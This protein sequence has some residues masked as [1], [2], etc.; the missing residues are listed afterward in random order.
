MGVRI[1]SDTRPVQV[2]GSSNEGQSRSRLARNELIP[3]SRYLLKRWIG[4]GGMGVI[5]EAEHVDVKRPVAVKILRPEYVTNLQVLEAFRF[6]ARATSD[7]DSPYLVKIHDFFELPDGRSALVMELLEGSD[8]SRRLDSVLPSSRVLGIARQV[9]KALQ[10]VH[11]SG[12]VHRDLK[13]ENI[14]LCQNEGR[15]DTIRVL[16]FGIARL[17]AQATSAQSGGTPMY[18]APEV[19]LG[20]AQ[21]PQAD[22]YALGCVLYELLTGITAFGRDTIDAT[23]QAHLESPP[24]PPSAH[25]TD[26]HPAL[27]AVVLRSLSRHAEDRYADMASFEAALCEAQIAAGLSTAWDDLP[28]PPEIPADQRDRLLAGM[29]DPTLRRRSNRWSAWAV[30]FAAVALTG[31]GVLVFT[32]P[33]VDPTQA[34][35][36]EQLQARGLAREARTAGSR[37]AWVYPPPDDISARTAYQ[38]VLALEELGDVG[39]VVA[40]DLRTDFSTTLV[41]LG[42]EYW[43]AEGGTRFAI[44]YYEQALLF[45]RTSLRALERS[46][47]A[48]PSLD[49][50]A[51][52]AANS[53]FALEELVRVEPLVELAV[54]D[55]VPAAK[56][57]EKV[58]RRR[59]VAPPPL[60]KQAK[61]TTDATGSAEPKNHLASSPQTS[62]DV[63]LRETDERDPDAGRTLAKEGQA[64]AKSGRSGKAK[65]LFERTLAKD[66]RNVSA[67]AGLRDLAFSA[68]DYARAVRHGKRAAALAPRNATHQLRL[69]DAYY[70]T[71][72]YVKAQSAYA[73][74]SRLGDERA[75]WR[76]ERAREKL[77]G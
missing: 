45:D 51:K 11:A 8:L 49:S 70:R 2:S 76:L 12:L 62:R 28:I 77:G 31:A 16:D 10:L 59:H 47:M 63:A 60:P 6:E 42:D 55:D 4:E 75:K 21:G 23:L 25:V 24:Q 14:F 52:R 19:V 20:A 54:K 72:K 33:E 15:P 50:F 1:A 65:L 40:A 3:G 74:A 5:Y 27:D 56:R 29:P 30:A 67:H 58:R 43:N 53:Q 68:G 18:T 37:A 41:R 66:S 36:P 48:L 26:I 64:A 44:A 9:C 35:S 61:P 46:S 34:L 71:H 22:I 17:S 57:I 38:A 13:P 32:Q 69:G 7:L 39:A 73:A